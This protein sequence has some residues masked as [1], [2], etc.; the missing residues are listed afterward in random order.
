MTELLFSFYDSNVKKEQLE[1]NMS[2]KNDAITTTE[3]KK[4]LDGKPKA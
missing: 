2:V 3:D 1:E 4:Y